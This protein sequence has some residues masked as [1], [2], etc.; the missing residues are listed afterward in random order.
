MIY[1]LQV[2]TT[3]CR[4]D[5]VYLGL[6]RR[7]MSDCAD[8]LRYSW[9]T[10]CGCMD[11][12]L[13]RMTWCKSSL[14][15]KMRVLDLP[16]FLRSSSHT[17]SLFSFCLSKISLNNQP[18]LDDKQVTSEAFYWYMA[19]QTCNLLGNLIWLVPASC[20]SDCCCCEGFSCVFPLMAFLSLVKKADC[21]HPKRQ[22]PEKVLRWQE[23]TQWAGNSMKETRTIDARWD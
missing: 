17:P 9:T 1:W 4:R 13:F 19:L 15:I 22:R 10:Y 14:Y 8:L 11:V 3:W 5:L 6:C 12:S 20:L 21:I 23:T 16:M 7:W 18:S 2:I